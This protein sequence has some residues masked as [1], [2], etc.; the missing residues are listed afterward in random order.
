[1]EE[2]GK[3]GKVYQALRKSKGFAL[4]AAA[5]HSVNISTLSRFENGMLNLSL[6]HFVQILGNIHISLDEFQCFFY[7][8]VGHIG[9][10]RYNKQLTESYSA[11]NIEELKMMMRKFENM[12]NKYGEG[13]ALP[14]E[15][16]MMKGIMH[17]L[18]EGEA[19]TIPEWRY[20]IR[21][22]YNID[23]WGAFELT[24]F[25]NSCFTLPYEYLEDLYR[26]MLNRTHYFLE[27][28]DYRQSF[29]AACCKGIQR[30]LMNDR[31]E[32]ASLI[33]IHLKSIK[34]I[35]QDAFSKIFVLFWIGMFNYFIN[36]DGSSLQQM[37]KSI[38]VMEFL[39]YSFA[40]Q[41]MKNSMKLF[42]SRKS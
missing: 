7:H 35:D 36:D 21:E 15:I 3:Y 24:L 41:H 23:N 33:I 31:P 10:T 18:G 28:P 39:G 14:L 22:L 4:K 19:P 37:Q 38:E 13:S 6:D 27:M 42:H 40:A 11:G 2:Y 26:K 9:E 32:L 20:L 1:M 30:F 29:F 16:T 12:Q 25:S 17:S 5:G 34:F 8:Y